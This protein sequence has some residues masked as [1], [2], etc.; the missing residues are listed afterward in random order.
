ML[1]KLF[2]APQ[3]RPAAARSTSS[4]ST[5]KKNSPLYTCI[6]RHSMRPNYL[7]K[8]V[9]SWCMYA[10]PDRFIFHEKKT[11]TTTIKQSVNSLFIPKA[12]M[13]RGI[14]FLPFC[15]SVRVCITYVEFTSFS[16]SCVKVSQVGYHSSEGIHIWT[17]CTLEGRLSFHDF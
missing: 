16:Q 14:Q 6:S 17:I 9:L 1:W 12:F 10:C 3:P 7:T 15:L 13:S 8:L 5:L 4:Q 2:N 11:K